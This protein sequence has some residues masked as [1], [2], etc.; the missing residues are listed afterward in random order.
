MNPVR[1][2]RAEEIVLIEFMLNQLG[3]RLSDF[4]INEQVEEYEQG[5]MGSISLGGN[6]EA[7]AGDL[8]QVRYVDTDSIPVII[9]LTQDTEGKLLD[10]D[11]WKEDFSKLLLYP[12]PENVEVLAT[13]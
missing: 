1:S 9:S 11:F 13:S 3:K 4:S 2:I 7:Y 10:L 8:L 12:T 6:P 5:K